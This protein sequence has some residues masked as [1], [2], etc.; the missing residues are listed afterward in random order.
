MWVNAGR[1]GKFGGFVELARVEGEKRYPTVCMNL[2]GLRRLMTYLHEEAEP[3][4][5]RA[6]LEVYR[7]FIV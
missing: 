1:V 7:E 5:R 6:F 3:E 4:F 2:L